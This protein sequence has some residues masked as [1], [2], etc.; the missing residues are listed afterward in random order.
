MIRPGITLEPADAVVYIFL[1]GKI[2]PLLQDECRGTDG[3]IDVAYRLATKSNSK[4]WTS[5]DFRIWRQWREKSLRELKR[6]VQYVV[7]TD[8]T[9]Y[10]DSIPIDK[11]AS[12]LRRI[13][14]P[15]EVVSLLQRCLQRWSHP[16]NVG[17]PQGYTASDLL[18]KLYMTPVDKRVQRDGFSHLRYVDDIRIFCPTKLQAKYAI[19]Q[20]SALMYSRG[21]TLQSAKTDILTKAEARAEFDGATEI[22]NGINAKLAEELGDLIGSGYASPAELI[23]L[24]GDREG[25]TPPVLERAFSEHFGVGSTEDF[26]ATLFHYLLVRLGKAGSRVAVAYCT[27]TLSARPEETGQILNYF[28]QIELE[29][30]EVRSVIEYMASEDAIYDYQLYQLL[31]WF[32]NQQIKDNQLLRLSRD[33]SRD[34]NH[35]H[36]LR[37][38]AIAYRG[39]H[40][41][42]TDLDE[43]END[44]NSSESELEKCDRVLALRR[45][46]KGRRNA[47]YARVEK[48]GILV[49]RAVRLAK[50]S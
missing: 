2:F 32:Y 28:S 4:E 5:H 15:D 33:W 26:N 30:S 50:Q 37:S 34:R 24:L 20:L 35:D 27:Q 6:K 23:E 46:E 25:P 29:P 31:R 8:I 41:D 36:W 11:L 10:Y 43:L 42:E 17:I 16:R 14:G 39:Q 7:T 3:K 18:A 13:G 40:G 38:Y 49:S 19:R 44:Y 9:G 21:L 45:A 48:E 47:F 22:I 12:E 1:V